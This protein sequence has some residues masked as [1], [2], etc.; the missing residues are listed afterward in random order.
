MGGRRREIF[1]S[2]IASSHKASS[3]SQ[4][5]TWLLYNNKEEKNITESISQSS[6]HLVCDLSWRVTRYNWRE[7]S[8]ECS[9][10]TL[11]MS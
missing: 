1:L 11:H 9:F 3:F 4:L 5:I 6:V 8:F 2:R 10:F 7:I